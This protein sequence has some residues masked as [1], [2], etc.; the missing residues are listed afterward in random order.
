MIASS[1]ARRSES[2]TP[3]QT[4]PSAE[5]G[6]KGVQSW[7]GSEINTISGAAVVVE[8][9]QIEEEQ[10]LVV[11]KDEDAEIIA[12]ELISEHQDVLLLHG[13]KQRYIHTPKYAVP[14][15]HTDREMLVN[16]Q[17][18]GLNPIDWKAPDFGF[19]LPSLPCIN[20][21][22]LAG[23]VVKAP[24]ANS[25]FKVGD[26]VMGISTDYRDS[27]KAAYQQYSVVPDF[28]A[29]KLP[30]TVSVLDAAPL[31]VAFVAAVLALGIC[32]GVDFG[33]YGD[34][35]GPNILKTTRAYPRDSVPEDI[36]EECFD[37]LREDERPQ[38]GEWIAI[39]GG[40]SASGC[41]AIQLAKLAGFRV[42]AVIDIARSGSRM[43]KYG[44]DLLVDRMDTT[45][46]IEI[47]KNVTNGNLRFS[48]DTRGRDTA[49]LLATAMSKERKDGEPRAHL[50]GLT[51]LPKIPTEGVVYHAVPI[52][53]FHEL[54][55]VGESL[56]I[57]L[58]KLLELQ[59]IATPEIV[60]ADGGLEGINDALDRLRDG[61][62]NGPRMVVP[63]P[64]PVA[65]SRVEA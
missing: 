4:P 27:R 46:A 15:L 44:A 7:P 34:A 18:V 14:E 43:L 29:C 57:W 49:A 42:I 13:P 33:T 36:R 55:S 62:V 9:S 54:P 35:R 56:M 17:A 21:R 31:G 8:K 26:I 2:L 30:K 58:E 23:K 48:L 64:R 37:K 16:V 28:N 22:D 19:G 5:G 45:R 52:K 11:E 41:C 10:V 38:P 61:T 60:V 51:G 12:E 24:K 53:L 1:Y 32:M 40:S 47:I 39:W 6:V 59:R 65:V 25:R 20:G 63:L 50:V 3:P